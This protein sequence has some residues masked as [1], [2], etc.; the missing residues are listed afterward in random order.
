MKKILLLLPIV[1][2][3][4]TTPTDI[5]KEEVIQTANVLIEKEKTER[6][7]LELEIEKIKLEQIINTP[8]NEQNGEN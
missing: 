2:F 6:V 8:K 3:S 5:D 1:I 4:C 7:R